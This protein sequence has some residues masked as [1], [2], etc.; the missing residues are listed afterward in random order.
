MRKREERNKEQLLL[1]G[2]GGGRAAYMEDRTVKEREK[3]GRERNA[4][5]RRRSRSGESWRAQH[6]ERGEMTGVEEGGGGFVLFS[7]LSLLPCL[8]RAT[9]A[10]V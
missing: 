8:P 6:W 3:K 5:K 9:E 2:R 7:L 10:P 1:R 4:A